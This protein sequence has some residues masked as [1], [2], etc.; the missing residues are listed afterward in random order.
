MALLPKKNK[1]F[2][3]FS[4][5]ARMAQNSTYILYEALIDP[6][7]RGAKVKQLY[8]LEHDADELNDEI[9]DTL[10]RSFITPMDRED[11]FALTNQLDDVVDYVEEI[12]ERM[13]LYRVG[14]P[15]DGA[16]ELGKLLVLC[17]DELVAA[18]DLLANIKNNREKILDHM[19][20]IAEM[21]VKG[22]HIYREEVARLFVGNVDPIDIIKWK[23]I[24]ELL[25]DALDHCKRIADQLKGVLMKY[26]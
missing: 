3:L 5:S 24:L 19:K 4:E 22:D 7:N 14:R 6:E 21:E 10:Y 23:E 25:E 1:F 20:N 11:I 17:A 26:A 16:I 13:S 18:F 15:T 8:D 2:S 9:L 12:V